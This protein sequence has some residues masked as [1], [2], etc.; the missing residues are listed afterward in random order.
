MYSPAVDEF[1]KHVQ[2]VALGSC[3]RESKG[4]WLA[5][6][7]RRMDIGSAQILPLCLR[8]RTPC[9]LADG[10]Q[11]R[12]NPRA[13]PS[14]FGRDHRRGCPGPEVGVFPHVQSD[15]TKVNTTHALVASD[16]YYRARRGIS[17]A[18]PPG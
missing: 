3:S 13:R 12:A 8:S 4:A 11:V 18:A 16:R 14:D 10:I 17:G 15:A 1:P 5:G 7:F 6:S 9:A 2:R